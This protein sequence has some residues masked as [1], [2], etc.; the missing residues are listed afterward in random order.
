MNAGA[1]VE[2]STFASFSSLSFL[3]FLHL[4]RSNAPSHPPPPP[5]PPPRPIQAGKPPAVAAAASTPLFFCCVSLSLA[6]SSLRPGAFCT[7]I[8]K[9]TCEPAEGYSAVDKFQT[10]E[11]K[12]AP[13]VERYPT[14][15]DAVMV[16]RRRKK[17]REK[18]KMEQVLKQ[19][20]TKRKS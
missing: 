16:R 6:V 9:G 3:Y 13:A 2:S 18:R 7:T 8:S 15:C 20:N 11:K 4:T 5:P 1:R 17:N 19:T 10:N 14:R 12:T